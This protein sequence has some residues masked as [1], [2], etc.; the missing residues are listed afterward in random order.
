[1]QVAPAAVRFLSIEPL[2]GPLGNID[3]KGI[4]WVIAGGESGPSARPPRLEWVR[5]I[6]DQC[7]RE[8]VPFFFKQWGGRTP[9]AGGRELEGEE[10]NAMPDYPTEGF[11]RGR[12]QVAS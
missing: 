11:G 9:K 8:S 7:A 10:H 2:L 5:D 12:L 6:R 3:L 4:S 1:M